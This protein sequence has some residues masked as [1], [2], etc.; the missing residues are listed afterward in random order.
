M[1]V[2]AGNNQLQDQVKISRNNHTELKISKRREI[3]GD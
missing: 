2:A 1:V 3:A